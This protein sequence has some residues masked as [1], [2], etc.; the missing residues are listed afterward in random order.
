MALGKSVDIRWGLS[1]RI[2]EKAGPVLRSERKMYKTM[3]FIYN[4]ILGDCGFIDKKEKQSD[5]T[6]YKRNEYA[7]RTPRILYSSPDQA[8]YGWGGASYDDEISA[9]TTLDRSGISEATDLQPIKPTEFFT[10]ST[11]RYTERQKDLS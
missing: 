4:S 7:S 11:R 8:Y 3:G 6:D 9:A 1:V 2:E 10:Q 5:Y